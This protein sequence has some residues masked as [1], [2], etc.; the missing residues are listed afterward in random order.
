MKYTPLSFEVN[1]RAEGFV[2]HVDSLYA[3]LATLHDQR[4]ARGLRYALVTVLVFI[5]LAKLAGEDHLRGIADWVRHRKE[6]LAQALGLAK[7]QAPHA[8]TY[9]RIL[10]HAVNVAEFEHVVRE[11]FERQPQ[12]GRSVVITLD[13]KTLRGTIPAGQ[14]QGVH[15]LA[16][17]LPEEGWVLMQVE[18]PGPE[19]EIGAALRVLQSL[20]LR[21]KVVTGD[22]I[23]A[24]R[25]LSNVVVR[26]GGDYLWMVKDNQE[27]LREEIAFLFQPE[28]CT[29]GFSPIPKDFRTATSLDKGHGRIEQRTL[30][31]S[32]MLKGHLDWPHAEQ[33]FQIQ[34]RF[35]RVKDGKV[36]QQVAYGVT[37]LSAERASAGQLL[38]LVR[39]H[40][41]IENGLHYRRDE[42]LREDRCR[43]RIG[44]AAE[45]MAIINN[46]VLG[47]LLR[48]RVK[49]VPEARRRFAAYLEEALKLI[50]GA[51]P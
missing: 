30:T 41:Q 22:A 17:Y 39:L 31:A 10:A 15:L 27:Q 12:A 20:D 44:H 23:L 19:N 5:I 9:S 47:L 6:A 14:M 46:L 13:G 7:A 43:L 48:Q 11:F 42:T 38:R 36:S 8:S 40:W 21:G 28:S 32:S 3:H 18:V 50:L 37:S 49:N 26:A 51:P 45:V 34:R 29:A 2:V 25:H 24:Q 4:D 16:A 35:V 1:L 33:V